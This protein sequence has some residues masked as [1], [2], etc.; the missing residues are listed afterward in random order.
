MAASVA[1]AV[2][3]ALLY[4]S[5]KNVPLPHRQEI[6]D[7]TTTVYL[8]FGISRFSSAIRPLFSESSPYFVRVYADDLPQSR[9]RVA[10]EV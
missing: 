5:I 6:T 9:V 1:V 2:Q 8:Q 3:T 4:F 7:S 10:S